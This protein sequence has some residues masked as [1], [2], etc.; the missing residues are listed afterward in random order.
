MKN[1]I[2]TTLS[3]FTLTLLTV[4]ATPTITLYQ[5]SNSYGAG[6]QFT[7]VTSGNGTFETFC[8]DTGHEFNPGSQYYY[9]IGNDTYVGSGD[10]LTIGSAYLYNSFLNGNLSGY[11]YGNANS[12]GSLQNVLWSLQ[13][14]SYGNSLDSFVVGNPF[15]NDLTSKFGTIN[16]AELPADGAYGIF[17]MNLYDGNNN[18]IQS[19]LVSVYEHGTL[20]VSSFLLFGLIPFRKYSY[21]K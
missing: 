20:M 7:A 4:V 12:A 16:N 5:N 1:K 17:V 19:Q 6:G 10:A 15:Y 9:S 3:I 11:Q 13:G 18:P 2:I 8:I 14:E 21:S